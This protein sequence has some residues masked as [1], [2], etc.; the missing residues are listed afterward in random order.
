MRNLPTPTPMRRSSMQRQPP[1]PAGA[2]AT[3]VKGRVVKVTRDRKYTGELCM[4]V[5]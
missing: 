5:F 2:R 1:H 3:F 4:D